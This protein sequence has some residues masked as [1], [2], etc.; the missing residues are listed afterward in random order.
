MDLPFLR[1][2][3][4]LEQREIMNIVRDA[5]NDAKKKGLSKPMFVLKMD[6]ASFDSHFGAHNRTINFPYKVELE[7]R[8]MVRPARDTIEVA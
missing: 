7:Q 5:E 8:E 6:Y 2:I 4:Q 3:T 1:P